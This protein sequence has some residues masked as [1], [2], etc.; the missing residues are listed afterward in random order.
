MPP[1]Q[2]DASH[3]TELIKAEGQGRKWPQRFHVCW[4]LLLHF[5]AVPEQHNSLYTCHPRSE[6]I[7]LLLPKSAHV[8]WSPSFV[9]LL[10]LRRH[11]R[12]VTREVNNPSLLLRTQRISR[13][14]THTLLHLS[15]LSF[16]CESLN[17]DFSEVLTRGP[18]SWRGD[19]VPS[20]PPSSSPW[21]WWSPWLQ[22]SSWLGLKS[23]KQ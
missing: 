18:A 2:S 10:L 20:T 3:L 22:G 8:F 21:L 7:F 9:F 11:F 12:P 23:S 15:Y 17:V 13:L 1:P 6:C 14:S 19:P 16:L 5:N 4:E